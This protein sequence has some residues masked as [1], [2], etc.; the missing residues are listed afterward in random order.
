MLTILNLQK[1]FGAVKA[2]KDASMHIEKGE[3]RAL[4]GANGSGKSTLVKVLSGLCRKDGGTISLDGAKIDIESPIQSFGFGISMSYQDLSLIPILSVAENMALG[5]EPRK[6]SGMID[7]EKI[8]AYAKRMIEKLGIHANPGTV[9]S[10]LDLSNQSLIEVAKALYTN[11][12]LLVLDEITASMHHDQVRRLFAFLKEKRNDGLSILF[13]SHRFDEVYDFCDTATILREGVSVKDVVLKENSPEKLV[14][15]MTG[16]EV[17]NVKAGEWDCERIS[18]EPLLMVNQLVINEAVK[19]VSMRIDKGE[20]VGIAGLQGQGQSEF[21]R[22]LFGAQ[23][24]QGGS[25]EFAGRPIK[26][27]S[28]T[29]AIRNG[30]AFISGDREKEGVFSKRSVSENILIVQNAMRALVSGIRTKQQKT[31]VRDI[32]K[33]L[34]IVAAG[35]GVPASSLS[36]GNQQKLVVGRWLLIKPNILLLDDPTKGVD[37]TSRNEINALLREMTKTGMSIIFSSSDNEELL[38]VAQ[39]IYVFY[40]GKVVRELRGADMNG[41]LLAATMLGANTGGEA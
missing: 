26:Q 25:L 19:G 22:A 24:Y 21:L 3:V 7:R 17:E 6:K 4:L 5:H 41:Q 23:A 11:P 33:T 31:Q 12:R 10:R 1:N 14:Y 29:T 15:Y 34:N 40:E 20:I 27:K 32:I 13:V 30:F 8:N 18:G 28:P 2:V 9:V 36:G 37:V 35:I 38:R 16:Q 39:R